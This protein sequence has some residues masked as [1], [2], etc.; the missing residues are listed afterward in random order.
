[1]LTHLKQFLSPGPFQ[2]LDFY[3]YMAPKDIQILHKCGSV[4]KCSE[5]LKTDILQLTSDFHNFSLG[6]GRNWP[7]T[8]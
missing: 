2:D 5:V 4:T 1:M 6:S 3:Q 7:L 8:E